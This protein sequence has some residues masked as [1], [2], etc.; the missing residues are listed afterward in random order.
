V[1][2]H[3]TTPE[4]AAASTKPQQRA[5]VTLVPDNSPTPNFEVP[6]T[7]APVTETAAGTPNEF[8]RADATAVSS[9][10]YAQLAKRA[11]AEKKKMSAM[12]DPRTIGG[13]AY[14]T[15]GGPPRRAPQQTAAATPAPP[16]PPPMFS[17]Q[18]APPPPLAPPEKREEERH[19]VARTNPKPVYQPLPQIRVSDR[20]VAR[21]EL[22]VGDDGR[23]HEV[24]VRQ[25]LGANTGR[26]IA[27]VQSWRFKPATLNGVP[28]SSSFTVELQFNP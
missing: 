5:N 1:P 24:N 14:N 12:V 21:V 11:Q 6:I 19:A 27:A 9:D 15:V 10:E 3:E 25:G 18:Q 28:V 26:L 2:G 17:A 7:S 22:T 13:V 23:V 16:Q 8:Q 20:A 4:A